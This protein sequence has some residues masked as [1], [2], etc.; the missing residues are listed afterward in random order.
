M[1]QP[2]VNPEEEQRE[3]LKDLGSRLHQ[4]RAEQGLSLERIEKKT[5]IPVRILKA[6]E[7]GHLEA[8]PEPIYIR[9]F[10]KQFAEA[11]GL[12][13][14]GFVRDLPTD[15]SF[16]QVK[17]RH[18]WRLPSL[19]IRP[20][21][22]YLLYILLVILSVKG[23]SYWLKQS[24][25]EVSQQQTPQPSVVKPTTASQPP[26][27]STKPIS[28]SSPSAAK[29]V[30]VDIKL[31]DKSWLKVVVDGKTEFEGI[32]PQGTHRTWAAKEQVTVRAGN[33]GS[34]LVAFNDQQAKQLGKPGQIQ[35]VTYQA[36]PKS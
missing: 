11:L 16:R 31:K 4:I 1:K 14:M 32:L 36:N 33:A 2:K 12:D 6:I 34:V 27:K 9:G 23:L 5:L 13:G 19:Q 26:K 28:I 8:L 22:L 29:P 15:L 20:L 18:W 7:S 3:K 30:V 10:M 25:L 21:H 35:E 24:A 17:S